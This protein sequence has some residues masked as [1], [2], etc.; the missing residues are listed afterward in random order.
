MATHAE[1]WQ[2]PTKNYIDMDNPYNMMFP[3]SLKETKELIKD[4]KAAFDDARR[5]CAYQFQDDVR[6]NHPALSLLASCHMSH[7]TTWHGASRINSSLCLVELP[8]PDRTRCFI[9]R[10]YSAK[11]FQATTTTGEKQYDQCCVFLG[12]CICSGC[13]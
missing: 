5:L 1:E 11:V 6:T 9:A 3:M 7:R 8:Q 4:V 13:S 10:Q 12:R 2:K